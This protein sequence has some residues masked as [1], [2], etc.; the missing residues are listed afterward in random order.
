[1]LTAVMTLDQSA[2]EKSWFISGPAIVWY[3]AAS[4]LLL[5]L[6]TANRYGYFGDEMYYFA[7][8]EHLAWGYVDQPPLI[9]LAAWL[10]R[11]L[12]G[13]SLFAFHLSPA[14]AGFALVWLSGVIARELGGGRFA[15]GLAALC[16]ACSGVYLILD[17]LF[18]MNAFEPLLWMGCAWVLIRIIKTGNQRLWIWFGII[19]GLG[20]ENKYSMGVFCLTAVA[21]VALTR[22][23]KAFKEK[24]IWIGGIIAFLIFL[25][26]LIWNVQHHWPFLE[27]MRNIRAS[28]RNNP[29]TPLGY[30]RAQIFMMTPVTFPVWLLGGLYFFF[31]RTGKP[32]VALG[33]SFISVLALFIVLH[34]KDY[35]AAPVYPMAFAG[36]AIAI[37]QFA[38]RRRFGWLRPAAVAAILLVTVAFLP[39]FAP[40]LSPES[41]L[42]YQATLPFKI[43]PDEKSMLAEPMPHYYS[44]DF[45]WEE[46]VRGVAKAYY[47]VPPEERSDTAIFASDFAAAGAI[48]LL[49]PKYGLPKAIS[50]HQSYWLWGPRHYTGKTMILVGNTPQGAG[51]W[52][53]QV[54]VIAE[55]NNPYA[56]PW[57][58]KPVLLCRGPKRFRTLAEVW[59]TIKHWD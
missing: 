15:Q 25:P 34:G 30:I 10:T 55:L 57:E 33:W 21:G 58:N 35:Y 6:L 3:I 19:A 18:T 53:N 24:W 7:C 37:E 51:R 4:V 56:S 23:R 39:L 11:H 17:H 20:L 42:R 26:N 22:E 5:H 9:A 47:S 38:L 40:V 43:Q 28:E 50:G 14:L 13:T 49:G 27:L 1:M 52:F 29:F 45:G 12:I 8:A 44:W 2:K 31:W 46:M 54:T 41:F 16:A 32:F 36:G 59:P 48:D